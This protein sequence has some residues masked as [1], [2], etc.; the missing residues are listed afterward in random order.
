MPRNKGGLADLKRLSQLAKAGKEAPETSKPAPRKRHRFIPP[1]TKASPPVSSHSSRHP[2]ADTPASETAAQ[3]SEEDRKLFRRAV[4]Q[5][6]P[7]KDPGRVIL[8]PTPAAPRALLEE[9]RLRAAGIE[10][11]LSDEYAPAPSEQDD[12]RHLKAGHGTDILRDLKRGKWPIGASLDLHGSTLDEAR[13]RFDRFL[14][15]CLEHEV[16]C[17]RIVHGKGH[18]SADGN[19]ILKITVRR[20]LTQVPEVL[21]YVECNEADGGAGAVQVLLK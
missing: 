8:K 6:E 17:V 15:S 18:G 7:M 16:K 3:L 13:G 9:R 10:R 19:A 5:V 12:S 1:G 20:W 4:R 11:M 21:A 14:A 2:A